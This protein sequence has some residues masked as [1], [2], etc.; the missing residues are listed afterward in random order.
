[1]EKRMYENLIIFSYH[2]YLVIFTNNIS[3][4]TNYGIS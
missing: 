2:C 4:F 3:N 1:M